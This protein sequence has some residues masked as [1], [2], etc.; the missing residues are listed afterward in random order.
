MWLFHSAQSDVLFFI[1]ISTVE[2][3]LMWL[4]HRTKVQVL[5]RDYISSFIWQLQLLSFL[6]KI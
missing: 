5:L 2:E 6:M 1:F 4:F 3:Q